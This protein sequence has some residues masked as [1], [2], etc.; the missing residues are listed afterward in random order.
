[1]GIRGLLGHCFRNPEKVG[2]IEDLVARANSPDGTGIKI[3]VDFTNFLYQLTTFVDGYV[4]QQNPNK[5]MRHLGIYGGEYGI[6]HLLVKRFVNTLRHHHIEIVCF[7]DPSQGTDLDAFTAKL[8]THKIRHVQDVKKQHQMLQKYKDTHGNSCIESRFPCLTMDQ[9]L[10]TLKSLD[11][12]IQYPKIEAESA[13]MDYMENCDLYTV[14]LAN[15]SD[16]CVMQGCRFIPMDKCT[17]DITGELRKALFSSHEV[18]IPLKELKCLIVTPEKVARSFQ[19]ENY[20]E[21]IEVAVL[22]GSDFT[23]PFIQQYKL[24]KGLDKNA[25]TIRRC[26]KVEHSEIKQKLK[27]NPEF[28]QAVE[29]TRKFY[30]NEKDPVTESSTTI[31]ALYSYLEYAVNNGSMNRRVLA[32]YN[33]IYSK[34]LEMEDRENGTPTVYEVTEDIRV[35]LYAMVSEEGSLMYVNEYGSTNREDYAIKKVHFDD[36]KGKLPSAIN[37]PS[38]GRAEQ[39][40]LFHRILS[41]QDFK[42]NKTGQDVHPFFDQYQDHKMSFKCY[43]INY[44]IGV[45]KRP[46]SN[47]T[48]SPKELFAVVYMVFGNHQNVP[49]RNYSPTVKYL[50]LS[51]YIQVIYQHAVHVAELLCIRDIVPEPQHLFIGHV[52]VHYYTSFSQTGIPGGARSDIQGIWCSL[53]NTNTRLTPE[54]KTKFINLKCIA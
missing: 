53:I 45:V 37:V 30:K 13:I 49:L 40:H 27:A 19:L 1:M 24:G 23:K 8:A 52:F 17:F 54:E 34:Y 42:E 25:E 39:L 46:S 38:I 41:Q 7:V 28:R 29:Y 48:L 3:L 14:V 16:F 12:K 36:V 47:F 51:T 35:S 6:L 15:D 11:V 10:T 43:V 2:D 33:K 32:W 5:Q 44:L 22:T 4:K 18:P 50:T 31:T 20:T 26:H 9:A 21:L